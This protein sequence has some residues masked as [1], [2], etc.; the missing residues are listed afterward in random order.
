MVSQSEANNSKRKYFDLVIHLPQDHL[1]TVHVKALED[2]TLMDIFNQIKSK[3]ALSP[4]NQL[5]NKYL[6]FVWSNRQVDVG[7]IDSIASEAF[8]GSTN[9]NSSR[10]ASLDVDSKE[11]DYTPSQSN[12]ILLF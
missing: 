4:V 11:M 6:F 9:L 12:G 10:L 3:V 8:D 1:R 5:I 7:I 2:W